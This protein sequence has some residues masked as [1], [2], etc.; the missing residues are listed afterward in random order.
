MKSFPT[1]CRCCNY[2]NSILH[3]QEHYEFQL[4]L[5]IKPDNVILLLL[6]TINVKLCI[7][8]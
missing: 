2:N 5:R 3:I 4:K 8:Q 1:I 7:L 6:K